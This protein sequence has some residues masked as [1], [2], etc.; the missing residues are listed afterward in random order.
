MV[1]VH[2][3]TN[4]ALAA[5]DAEQLALFKK[6]HCALGRT[7]VTCGRTPRHRGFQLLAIQLFALRLSIGVQI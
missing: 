4:E 1:N 2:G 6:L 3:L 7:N 5:P